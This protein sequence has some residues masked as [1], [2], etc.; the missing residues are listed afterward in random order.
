GQHKVCATLLA[1]VRKAMC[2]YRESADLAGFERSLNAY[3]E[4]LWEHMRKEEEIVLPL[5][6]QH[7]TGEDWEAIHAAFQANRSQAW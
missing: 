2:A 3:A 7:L 5:A 1:S 6:E 4:F